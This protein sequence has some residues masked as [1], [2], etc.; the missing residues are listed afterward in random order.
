MQDNSAAYGEVGGRG[1]LASK[2]TRATIMR[3]GDMAMA[4]SS[5]AAHF[6]VQCTLRTT[7]LPACPEKV[8]SVSFHGADDLMDKTNKQT[9]NLDPHTMTSN[10]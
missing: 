2:A 10:Q 5:K 7:Y 6:E 9:P 1:P 3:T 8:Y 4:V